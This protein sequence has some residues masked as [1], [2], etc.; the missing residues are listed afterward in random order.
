MS[1]K[2]RS[3]AAKTRKLEPEPRRPERYAESPLVTRHGVFRCVVYRTAEGAEEVALIRGDVSGD[4][5]LTRLHS[6]C[7]T[8]EVFGSLHCD[9]GP[10]LA[11]ALEKINQEGRGILL[12]LR[13]EGRG[14][15][16]GNKIR[17]YA[18]QSQGRDTVDANRALGFADDLRRYDHAA[19]ILQDLGVT[20]VRLMTN[21]PDKVQKLEADGI[22]VVERVPHITAAGPHN[23]G[24]LHAKIE[25]M[26]HVIDPFDLE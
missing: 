23:R 11:L 8:G 9:C 13:Q 26:G 19:A 1:Q 12:Y 21:N 10:Q 24:Y 22:R 25:R 6:E 20:S 4:A 18:L 2:V 17:A 16:L 14:I 7:L 3:A 15:G 5:V